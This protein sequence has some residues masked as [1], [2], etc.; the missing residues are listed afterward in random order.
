MVSDQLVQREIRHVED[1]RVIA[2]TVGVAEALQAGDVDRVSSL[3][4]PA[5]GGQDIE[6][7]LVFDAQGHE[8]AHLIGQSNGEIMNVSPFSARTQ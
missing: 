1:A 7:L 2:F 8:S 5:V 3:A 6:S 4:G